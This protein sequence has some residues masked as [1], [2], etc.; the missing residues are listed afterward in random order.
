MKKWTFWSLN[1]FHNDIDRFDQG[2]SKS[3]L[4]MRTKKQ[5]ALITDGASIEDLTMMKRKLEQL[6]IPCLP[7]CLPMP[8]F[9]STAGWGQ[10]ICFLS[11]YELGS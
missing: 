10:I 4:Y 2:I 8:T 5:V 1:P 3:W 6:R 11:W 7:P 9:E